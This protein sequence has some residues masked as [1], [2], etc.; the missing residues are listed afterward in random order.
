[1]ERPGWVSIRR[2][3]LKPR[4]FA[5]LIVAAAFFLSTQGT[6]AGTVRYAGKKISQGSVAVVGLAGD[7]VQ[8]AGEGVAAGGKATGSALKSGITATA[9]GAKATPSLA[10]RGV[11]GAGKGIAKAIW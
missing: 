7:G 4:L 5:T 11:K 2:C 1:M 6:Q 8:A 9:K 3:K 10:V